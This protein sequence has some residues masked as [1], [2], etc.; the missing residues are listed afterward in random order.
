MPKSQGQEG[1]VEGT[2]AGQG[3]VSGSALKTSVAS[4]NLKYL[5]AA[6]LLK[7]EKVKEN[8]AAMVTELLSDAQTAVAVLMVAKAAVTGLS[9]APFAAG[10]VPVMMLTAAVPAVLSLVSEIKKDNKDL[11][12]LQAIRDKYD[13]TADEGILDRTRLFVKMHAP[14]HD[15]DGELAR[16][17]PPKKRVPVKLHYRNMDPDI[18]KLIEQKE[19]AADSAFSLKHIFA[20]ENFKNLPAKGKWLV[21]AIFNAYALSLKVC[22][23]EAP[24]TYSSV[25]TGLTEVWR[26]AGR[27]RKALSTTIMT[28]TLYESLRHMKWRQEELAPNDVT[29]IETESPIFNKDSKLHIRKLHT[30]QLDIRNNAKQRAVTAVGTTAVASFVTLALWQ[31]AASFM[32]GNPVQ[33]ASYLMMSALLSMPS[34]RVLS[35]RLSEL[36]ENDRDKEIQLATRMAKH[37]I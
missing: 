9:L 34:L 18:R 30:L 7:S 32:A 10:I 8:N 4:D 5:D 15:I 19:N 2:A 11:R 20:K 31:S 3:A 25:K 21:G 16:Q 12:I 14:H 33:G 36:S 23:I 24:K 37:G 27:D 1:H 17:G 28:P 35:D 26:V 13:R 22:T 29:D 6:I